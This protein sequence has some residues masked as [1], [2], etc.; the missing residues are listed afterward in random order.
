[1]A[2]VKMVVEI[3]KGKLWARKSIFA[4]DELEDIIIKTENGHEVSLRDV[5]KDL[6]EI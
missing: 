3:S 5:L 2:Q 6:G 1:M 4:G